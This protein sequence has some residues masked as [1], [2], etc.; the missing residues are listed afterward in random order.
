[1]RPTDLSRSLKVS[2]VMISRMISAIGVESPIETLTRIPGPET[3]RSVMR[4]SETVGV[5][6]KC[7]NAAMVHIN[8]FDELI[9]DQ[10]GTRAALNAALSVKDSN[11]LDKFEQ[12]SRYQVFKGMS[13][14]LGVQS[15][16]WLTCMMLTPSGDL[17]NSVN[18]STIHGTLG[19]RRLRPDTT[20]HFSYGVPPKYK[21]QQQSPQ[22][23]DIDLTRFF[24]HTPAPLSVTQGNG[25]IINTFAPELAG[26]DDLYDM[27]AQVH[28]PGGSNR[29]AA[30]GRNYR[31]TSVIPDIPV[32]TL[33][34]DVII[35]GDIFKDIDPNVFV[36]NTM[37]KGGADL[38]D[39]TRILDRVGSN[40][41]IEDL[42][43][44]LSNLE[45]NEFPKYQDMVGSLCKHN[46]YD[47]SE[48]RTHRLQVQYP[49]YGFQY[50]IAYKVPAID[51][52]G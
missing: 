12:S 27:L 25:Q 47:P 50:V 3:L 5:S 15:N 8:R 26:K 11:S 14:V 51:S 13:Q 19:L 18:V 21:D 23:Q 29:F 32:V 10:Y 30:P 44:G 6:K 1:M 37:S 7:V 31:G 17:T 49:V 39:P 2:R 16:L 41:E 42:G 38:E 48:F 43:S 52:D 45:M 24:T 4:A 36:Y 33:I 9:R 22:R 20:V 35:H 28:V 46:G 40:E 34:S